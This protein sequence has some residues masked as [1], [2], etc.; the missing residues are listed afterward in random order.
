[1]KKI[2][3]IVCMILI[4]MLAA[5][6]SV[7]AEERPTVTFDGSKEIKYTYHDK[8]NFG[9][10]FMG[11]LPGEE[12][13]QEIVLR[14]TSDKNAD[15][16]MEVEIIRALEEASQASGAAYKF[17]LGITQDSVNNGK[18]SII[19]GGTAE[20]EAWIGGDKSGLS[21]INDVLKNYGQKGIKV[22]TL[23]SGETA[24]ISLTVT[25]DGMTGGNT[26]QD[27]KGTFEFTFH[28][29]YENPG[30][31]IINHV[32]GKDSILL[33]SVKT[34]DETKIIPGIISMIMSITVI[35][36]LLFHR[37]VQK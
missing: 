16:Y 10:A 17:S 25:L 31:T 2:V 18:K 27:L 9:N 22:A 33:K 8:E 34:G 14:N 26:Y 21:Q 37:K 6:K 13:K 36:I 23:K 12:R 32:N 19:Y 28:A 1:M 11:M 15:F 20:G 35:G 3:N 29:G 5:T 4:V 7:Y 24:V 30:E